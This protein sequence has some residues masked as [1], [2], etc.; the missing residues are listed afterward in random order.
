MNLVNSVLLSVSLSGCLSVGCFHLC[1]LPTL[2]LSIHQIENYRV[3][4]EA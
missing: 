1:V 2:M 4:E 3:I